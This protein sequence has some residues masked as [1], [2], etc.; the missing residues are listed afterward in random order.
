MAICFFALEQ[1]PVTSPKAKY[2]AISVTMTSHK[3]NVDQLLFASNRN[4]VHGRC[5]DSSY[6]MANLKLKLKQFEDGKER[7]WICID[8]HHRTSWLP[9]PWL[10][11]QLI[12]TANIML[13][14]FTLMTINCH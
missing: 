3:K 6:K 1:L 7:R 5:S 13:M 10:V 8:K 9:Q 11:K 2:H 14:R 12:L 4:V